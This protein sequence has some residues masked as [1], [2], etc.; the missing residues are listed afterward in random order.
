MEYKI[1][2]NTF[3]CIR[4]TT[5]ILIL[6]KQQGAHHASDVTGIVLKHYIKLY[7]IV[8]S[9][10]SKRRA[11]DHKH[12]SS[13]KR[14]A[15]EGRS[16]GERQCHHNGHE[17][18]TNTLHICWWFLLLMDPRLRLAAAF[19]CMRT[20]NVHRTSVCRVFWLIVDCQQHKSNPSNMFF[21]TSLRWSGVCT[22]NV[23]QP[24]P[25]KRVFIWCASRPAE[26][27]IALYNVLD[28]DETCAIIHVHTSH[29]NQH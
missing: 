7:Y 20:K 5:Y 28:T 17:H 4:K 22:F 1:L 2:K 26:Q 27:Q 13:T 16:T 23:P 6:N 11:R 12:T 3:T 18:H 10:G 21:P 19:C 15:S 8:V 14:D 9:S 29:S 24:Y 25:F